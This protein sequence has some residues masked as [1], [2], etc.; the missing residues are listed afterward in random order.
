[1]GWPEIGVH[2]SSAGGNAGEGGVGFARP[3]PDLDPVGAGLGNPHGPV[4]EHGGATRHGRLVP[5]AIPLGRIPVFRAQ[6]HFRGQGGTDDGPAT[7]AFVVGITLT[8]YRS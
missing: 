3:T 1:M 8:Q 6:L 7:P 5:G 4:A 2:G